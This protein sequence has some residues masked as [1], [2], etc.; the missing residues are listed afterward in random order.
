M[1]SPMEIP[2]RTPDSN[3]TGDNLENEESFSVMIK[4]LRDMGVPEE[5]ISEIKNISIGQTFNGKIGV[6]RW[7]L[8][9]ESENDY[10]LNIERVDEISDLILSKVEN[11]EGLTELER[12][13]KYWD[14]AL[15]LENKI[16]VRQNVQCKICIVVPIFNERLERIKKQI[17]SIKN[18]NV[19]PTLY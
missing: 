11:K 16:E 9:R 3:Q 17:E 18:Q 19:D 5:K 2:Q 15:S 6:D 1:K 13:K 4:D 14:E 12:A 7:F 8:T 10:N